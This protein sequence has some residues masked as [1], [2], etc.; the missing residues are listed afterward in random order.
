MLRPAN[1]P[2]SLNTSDFTN[3]KLKKAIDDVSE[4]INSGIVR[5]LR[6]TSTD[7]LEL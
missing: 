1:N 3:N 5:S 2:R 7:L 4:H 6:T